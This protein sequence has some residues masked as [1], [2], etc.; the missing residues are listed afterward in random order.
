LILEF[1]DSYLAFEIKKSEKITPR[2]AKNL[3]GLEHILDKPLKHA[4]ILSNDH[5]TH[6]IQKNI[7]AVNVNM[8]LG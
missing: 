4:Y 7:T 2:E 8:F 6:Q 1:P 3:I 5:K